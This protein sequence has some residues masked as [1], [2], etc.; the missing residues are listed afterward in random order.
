MSGTILNQL[1]DRV[2]NL[3]SK[4]LKL[5]KSIKKKKKEN[6]KKKY[7]KKKNKYIL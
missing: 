6:E 1:I 5:C 2:S 3:E 7:N 4:Y